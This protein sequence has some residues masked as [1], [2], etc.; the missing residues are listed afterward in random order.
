MKVYVIRYVCDMSYK[1]HLSGNYWKN[2]SDTFLLEMRLELP[3]KAMITKKLVMEEMDRMIH[4]GFDNKPDYWKD[5][6]YEVKRIYSISPSTWKAENKRSFYFVGYY[7]YGTDESD[8]F[9]GGPIDSKFV[10]ITNMD[11]LKERI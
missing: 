9:W 2:I 4:E 5:F 11:R 1:R 10:L 6:Y 3:R 8:L 7:D